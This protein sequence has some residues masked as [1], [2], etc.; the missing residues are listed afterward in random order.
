MQEEIENKT[1]TLIVNSSKF[2]GRVLQTAIARFLACA[3]RF[4]RVLCN[5][6]G[7]MQSFRPS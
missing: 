2:S 3:F 1:V 4:G 7:D 5:E 6:G